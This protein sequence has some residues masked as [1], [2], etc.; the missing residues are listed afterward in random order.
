MSFKRRKSQIELISFL[1]LTV[2]ALATAAQ[3]WSRDPQRWTAEDARHILL[4][5]PWA[6]P[7]TAL[8]GHELTPEDI[9]PAPLPGASEA[10]VAGPQ[11]HTGAGWDGGPGRDTAGRT[12]TLPVTVRWDSALPVR[13][14][15]L[16]LPASD[17]TPGDLYTEAQIA[18][19][20]IIT[21]TGLV[22]AGRYAS[23]GQIQKESSSSDDGDGAKRSQDPEQLLED[24]MGASRLVPRQGQPI[25]PDDVKLDAAT[26]TL[27]VFFPRAA[28]LGMDA[29]EVTFTTQFGSMRVSQ[30]FRLREMK[31]EGRLEL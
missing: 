1:L 25:R 7:G 12:P 20:Y 28:G 13:E 16:K 30:R 14:A 22:P 23:T 17:R 8:F 21:V 10:G 4:D 31:Y 18:K 6:Q 3:P 29:R 19:D 2:A 15:V 24:L 11:A 5:S 27:H 26:G 9:P